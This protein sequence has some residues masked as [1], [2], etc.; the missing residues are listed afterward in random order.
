M[1]EAGKNILFFAFVI[2]TF[3]YGAL[4]ENALFFIVGIAGLIV[5]RLAFYIGISR[6]TAMI[7][8]VLLAVLCFMIAGFF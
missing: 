2:L 6:K 5:F 7:S 3:I 1:D 8:Y 4:A